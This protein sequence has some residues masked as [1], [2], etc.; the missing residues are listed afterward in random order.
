M[1][2]DAIPSWSPAK[3]VIVQW[4]TQQGSIARPTPNRHQVGE[5]SLQFCHAR[6]KETKEDTFK[7]NPLKAAKRSMAQKI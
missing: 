1:V 6:K 7:L 2:G 3:G 4:N 5:G